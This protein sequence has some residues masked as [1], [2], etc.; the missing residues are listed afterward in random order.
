MLAS[1][2][3]S[4]TGVKNLFKLNYVPPGNVKKDLLACFLYELFSEFQVALALSR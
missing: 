4:G 1:A 3:F 2:A